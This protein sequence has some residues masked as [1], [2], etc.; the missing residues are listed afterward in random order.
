MTGRKKENKE[1]RRRSLIVEEVSEERKV[2]NQAPPYVWVGRSR[3]VMFTNMERNFFPIHSP[4]RSS[5]R[6]NEEE[7]EDDEEE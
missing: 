3:G 5:I 2:K 4:Y 7:S 6:E 1:L